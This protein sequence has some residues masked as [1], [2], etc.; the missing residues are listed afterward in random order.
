[1]DAKDVFCVI[2]EGWLFS[3]YHYLVLDFWILNLFRYFTWKRIFFAQVPRGTPRII[4]T[5]NFKR[6]DSNSFANDLKTINFAVYLTGCRSN[7]IL[8]TLTGCRSNRLLIGLPDVSKIQDIDVAWALWENTPI[9]KIRLRNQPSYPWNSKRNAWT[10]FS[11]K[12]S[13]KN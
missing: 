13:C 4:E 1:M 6:F 3:C 9:I 10:W 8:R 12:D 5:R 7:S 2:V 11:K